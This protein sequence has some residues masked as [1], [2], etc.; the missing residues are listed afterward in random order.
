MSQRNN[1][2][3]ISV[4]FATSLMVGATLAGCGNASTETLRAQ[5]RQQ[6]QTSQFRAAV[7]TLKNAV[8]ESPNE[9]E[10]RYQLA[11]V[12]LDAG[13]PV[14]AEKEIRRALQLGFRH[15]AAMAVLGKSLVLQGEFQKVLDETAQDAAKNGAELLCVRAEAYLALGKPDDAVRLYESVLL[16]QPSFPAALTGL[17]RVA[18]IAGDAQKA[19]LYAARALAAAPRN[20]DVLLFE[21]D[22]RRAENRPA[23]ALE[24][25][26]KVLSINPAHRSAYVEK[27]YLEIGMGRFDAAQADLDAAREIAPT[28][29]LVAYTQALLDFSQG[30]NADAQVSLQ[31]VLRVA[32]EH[33]PTVL[34]AGALCLNLGSLHQAE[35]HLRHYLEKNPHNVYARKMLAQTLLRSGHS[36]DALEVLTPALAD[37]QQDVQLLALAGE[38]YMQARNFNKAEEYFEKASTLDP[39]AANLRTSVALSKLG[40][41]QQA[42]AVSDLQLATR[43]DAKSQQ[44]GMALVRTELGLQ[45]FDSA[46]AAV[47][48]LEKAQPGVAAVEDVKGMVYIGKRDTVQARIQFRKALLTQPSYFP[49]ASNLAQLDMHENKPAAAR[50]ELLAFVEK[51]PTSIEGMTALASLDQSEGKPDNATKWLERASAAQ[52]DAVAPAVNLMGQ[53]LRTGATQKALDLARKLL[54]TH[55]GEPDLLDLLGRGFLANRQPED[56]LS[57]YKELAQALPLSAYA[58]MQVAAVQVLLQRYGA[59]EASVKT[60]LALQPDFPAAQLAMAELYARKGSNELALMMA[61]RLQTMHPRGAAGFQLE[62]DVLIGQGK[63]VRALPAFEQAFAFSPTSELLIKTANAQRLAGKPAEAGARLAAWLKLH[64]ADVRVQLFVASTLSADKQYKLA[65]AQLESAVKL[66]PSN[67]AAL[68]NLALAYQ[69]A[70]DPRAQQVAEQAYALAKETP[71]VMDTLGWILVDGG[72]AARGLSILQQASAKA[73]QARDIRYHMA[74]GLFKTGDKGGA[75]KELELLA[76]GDMQF[77][78]ADEARALLKQLQ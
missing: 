25:Y 63:P 18:F 20:T 42:Q 5:A 43:L 8:K 75:R 74:V 69:M 66:Q 62:G 12:Y 17:G 60:A 15:D 40:K 58:Q 19:N 73:T 64:P 32:P 48:A 53:Y 3:F 70:K 30:K 9:P 11:T 39:K 29:V 55:P 10:T 67:V 56:A 59:A 27:A 23:L 16:A 78:Q 4:G 68:N 47:L 77:A 76:A 45:H 6:Q 28:S 46:L 7:I 21:G 71:T 37:S 2:L 61:G 52:A 33:M 44:A 22:L 36:P 50:E 65:A 41:G 51:N 31:K 13:D 24:A 54:V 14:S 49:A 1:K 26:G 57:T 35:H 72:D 38:S 34:L